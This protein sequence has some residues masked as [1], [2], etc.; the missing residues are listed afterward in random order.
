[1]H[2][3]LLAHFWELA[4]VEGVSDALLPPDQTRSPTNSSHHR[5]SRSP[6][7]AAQAHAARRARAGGTPARSLCLVEGA[8]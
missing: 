8:G 7:A 5:R 2:G 4:S 6:A 3:H 1:M